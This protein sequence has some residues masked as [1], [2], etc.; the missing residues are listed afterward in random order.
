MD[1]IQTVHMD[2]EMTIFFARELEAR[3]SRTYDVVRAP[4]K[5]F[6]LIPVSTDAGE[7]AESIVWESYEQTGIAKII[8]NYSDDLPTA[9]VKGEEFV[10]RVKSIGN[11]YVYSLQEIRAAAMAGKPLPQR[12]ASAAAEAHRMLWNKIAFYGDATHNIPGW[13]TNP[14]IPTVTVEADGNEN[15]GSNSTEFEH[16]T[17]DQIVRDMH[18]LVHS[19]VTTTHGVERPNT[20]VMPLKQYTYIASRRMR[21]GSDVTILQHFL[22]TS[23]FISSVEWADELIGQGAGGT[24]IMIAYDRSPDKMT[25]EM[26]MMFRQHNV[27][28]NN[29]AYKVPCESR[30]GGVL[31][32]YPLSQAIGEGI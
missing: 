5:A 10:S 27:Q 7:A 20:L 1:I 28:E 13:L 11:S 12:K 9:D 30:I 25:L 4:L 22:A 21:D 26:P 19:I 8:S 6:E 14:N 3:K 18:D 2:E 32:Y 31:I 17:G 29:L 15:G 16:K 24:D 23:P